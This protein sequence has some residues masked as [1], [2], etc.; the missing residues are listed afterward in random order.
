M[1]ENNYLIN[2][3]KSNRLKKETKKS[4]SL[5]LTRNGRASRAILT[6]HIYLI[7]YRGLNQ[8]VLKLLASTATT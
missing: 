8:T 3:F 4:I 1:K 5:Y 6:F 7:D 2:Y